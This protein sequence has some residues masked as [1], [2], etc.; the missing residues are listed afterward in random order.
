MPLAGAAMTTKGSGPSTTRVGTG[1]GT[2]SGGAA[3]SARLTVTTGCTA[4]A[5]SC[6]CASAALATTLLAVMHMAQL[7]ARREPNGTFVTT[8][9][10]RTVRNAT[11]AADGQRLCHKNQPDFAG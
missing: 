4:S 7:Q 8:G 3:G 5:G 11:A 2:R 1:C 9:R 10:F 6:C